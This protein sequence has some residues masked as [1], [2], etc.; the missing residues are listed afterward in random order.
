MGECAQRGRMV[1]QLQ[2]MM[3]SLQRTVKT[4]QS[5]L[6]GQQQ[7]TAQKNNDEDFIKRLKKEKEQREL[8]ENDSKKKKRKK[9]KRKEKD[10]KDEKKEEK[11]KEK[12][13]VVSAKGQLFKTWMDMVVHLPQYFSLFVDAGYEDLSY[14]ENMQLTEQ[15]LVQ[16]GIEKRGHRHKILTEIKKMSAKHSMVQSLRTPVSSN[17]ASP[18]KV[19]RMSTSPGSSV[20]SDG[21]TKISNADIDVDEM[22]MGSGGGD[23]VGDDLYLDIAGDV[24]DAED[25]D[26]DGPAW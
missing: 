17:P 19:E 22:T 14:I 12:T 24:H 3:H 11:E 26:E 4:I 5:E 7:R 21:F 6:E 15:D 9:K 10:R 2:S 18:E 23:G 25:G 16:I 8:K 20:L 13:V 1:K